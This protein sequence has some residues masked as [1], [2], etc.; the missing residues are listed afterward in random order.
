MRWWLRLSEFELEI[1]YRTGRVHQ[2]PDALSRL[3][4]PT[5][6]IPTFGDQIDSALVVTRG[7]D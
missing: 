4:G 2:V 3:I 6:D 5:S 1:I 7:R